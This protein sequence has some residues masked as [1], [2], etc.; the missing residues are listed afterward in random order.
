MLNEKKVFVLNG[1][2]QLFFTIFLRFTCGA[3]KMNWNLC[4]Y[5][6]IEFNRHWYL[7]K[8]WCGWRLLE[9]KGRVRVRSLSI[10]YFA[11]VYLCTKFTWIFRGVANRHTIHFVIFFLFSSLHLNFECNRWESSC[12]THLTDSFF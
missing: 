3:R 2:T 5:T 1:H 4:E 11:L 10:M 6:E 9:T 7:M 12:C 8:G